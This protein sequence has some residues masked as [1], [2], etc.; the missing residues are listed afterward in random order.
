MAGLTAAIAISHFSSGRK[1]IVIDLYEASPTF[2]EVGAGIGMYRRTWRVVKALG[3]EEG[4]RKVAKAP[5]TD[6]DMGALPAFQRA[7]H[8][9]RRLFS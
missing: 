1:D 8:S 3:L 5:A 2:T 6:D 4:L 7:G 9:Q